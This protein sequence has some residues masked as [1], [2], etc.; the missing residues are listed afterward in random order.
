MSQ[1]R[2]P[3]IASC[4]ASFSA[5]RPAGVFL[6]RALVAFLSLALLAGCSNPFESG[7]TQSDSPLLP[8]F[9]PCYTPER[10]KFPAR[11]R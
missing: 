5:R 10:E 11:C 6:L 7:A 2:A 8:I 3:C 9:S 1:Y 4:R